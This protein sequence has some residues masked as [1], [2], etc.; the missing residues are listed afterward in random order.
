MLDVLAFS[1]PWKSS[2]GKTRMTFVLKKICGNLEC[3]DHGICLFIFLY[4]IIVSVCLFF[5]YISYD[6]IC[7]FSI[8]NHGICNYIHVQ[9]STSYHISIHVYVVPFFNEIFNND[10]ILFSHAA[11]CCHVSSFFIQRQM[12]KSPRF[13]CWW[14]TC[15]VHYFLLLILIHFS[16]DL[17]LVFCHWWCYLYCV[18]AMSSIT[19]TALVLYFI[20]F[21]KIISQPC[22]VSCSNKFV[23]CRCCVVDTDWF[24]SFVRFLFLTAWTFS[25]E[26]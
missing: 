21:E 6:G 22:S 17:R 19:Q 12:L 18:N 10:M 16:V 2:G 14:Q 20:L 25:L 8:S 24:V 13:R 5:T 11:S 4:Q 1:S 26:T 3:T 9:F 15:W 23:F 7:L